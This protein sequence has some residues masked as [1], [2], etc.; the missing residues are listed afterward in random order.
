MVAQNRARNCES[1]LATQFV[2]NKP[3]AQ[4]HDRALWF[5]RAKRDLAAKSLPEWE[6]LRDHASAI[7]A[8]CV[9]HLAD[10]LEEFTRNAERLG[11]QVHWAQNGE[12]A[13]AASVSPIA[14]WAKPIQ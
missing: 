3:R 5:V 14:S 10:Y 2:A 4:W 8:H 13:L 11:V 9:A 12:E 7:K 6:E 1:V